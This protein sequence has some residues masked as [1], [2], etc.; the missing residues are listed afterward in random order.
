MWASRSRTRLSIWLSGRGSNLQA[1]VASIQAGTLPAS[2]SSVISDRVASPGLVWAQAQGLPAYHV[3][4]S[5]QNTLGPRFHEATGQAP[6]DLVVLAGYMRVL[7]ASLLAFF[8][9]HDMLPLNIHPSLLPAYP[10]LNTHE[11]V[12]AAGELEHGATVHEVVAALDAGPI[13]AQARLNT[14]PG[15][16]PDVL[17]ER[18]LHLEHQLYPE[19]LTWFS[20][21]RVA[22]LNDGSWALEGRPLP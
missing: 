16:A 21:N 7:P 11:R 2:I 12:M 1:I 18:V 5:P 13:V 4:F 22:M 19:V 6:C 9:A 10:G 8:K 14:R 15:E 17:A 20:Q 3:P